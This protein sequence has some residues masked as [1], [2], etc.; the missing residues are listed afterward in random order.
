VATK[1]KALNRKHAATYRAKNPELV[2]RRH[3]ETYEK[4][5]HKYR[6]TRRCEMKGITVEQYDELMARQDGKCAICERE[7]GDDWS[8]KPRI[9]HCHEIGKVRGL[10]CNWCNRALGFFS[11]S[12]DMLE[13]AARYIRDHTHAL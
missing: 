9:D 10:L 12:P 13:K 4:N 3:T 7:F 5:K 11:D 2:R 6:H 8:V 1:D